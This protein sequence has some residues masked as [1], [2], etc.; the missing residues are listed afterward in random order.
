M[1]RV[2][3][4]PPVPRWATPSS[5][6]TTGPSSAAWPGPHHPGRHRAG[7]GLGAA[8]HAGSR[9]RDPGRKPHQPDRRPAR[10]T[11]LLS[12][13]VVRGGGPPATL[14][15]RRRSRAERPERPPAGHAGPGTPPPL[16]ARREEVATARPLVHAGPRRPHEGKGVRHSPSTSPSPTDPLACHRRGL[17][18][19]GAS[20]TG[21]R[22]AYRRSRPALLRPSMTRSWSSRA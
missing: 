14:A 5:P 7:R 11:L 12:K 3:P 19:A 9:A 2:R 8:A 17:P 15:D 22:T 10:R 21:L 13:G 1:R 6:S 20:S 4:F 18:R 16:Q